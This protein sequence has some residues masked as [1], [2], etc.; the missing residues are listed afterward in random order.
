LRAIRSNA[1]TDSYANGDS[2]TN[3]DGYAHSHTNTYCDAKSNTE[4][5]T[6]SASSPNAALTKAIV[7]RLPKPHL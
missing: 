7:F 6:D 3:A 5:A 2:N 4:A 1:D